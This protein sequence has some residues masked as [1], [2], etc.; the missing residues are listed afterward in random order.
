MSMC[1]R[2]ARKTGTAFEELH[3]MYSVSQKILH[4]GFVAIFPKRL[5]IFRPNLTCLLCIPIYARL[6]NFVQLTA[7]LTKLC[8]IKRDHPHHVRKMS[9]IGRNAR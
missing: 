7:T 4:Q 5:G 3:A 9:T 1:T 8:H 2:Y 6:R